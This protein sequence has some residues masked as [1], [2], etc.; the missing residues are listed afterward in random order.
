MVIGV[1]RQNFES[2]IN[3]NLSPRSHSRVVEGTSANEP[4]FSRFS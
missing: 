3:E 4:P 1:T 2:A